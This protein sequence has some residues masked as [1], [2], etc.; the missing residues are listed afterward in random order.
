MSTRPLSL[1]VLLVSEHVH[2]CARHHWT[3]LLHLPVSRYYLRSHEHSLLHCT[4]VLSED[5]GGNET[6]GL[7]DAIV[8]VQFL[9]R[10]VIHSTFDNV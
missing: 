8:I 6:I 1:I 7:F 5:L 3:R 2:I 4:I 9:L 10:Y